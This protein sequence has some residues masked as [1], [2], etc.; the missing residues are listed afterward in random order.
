MSEPATQN[1]TLYQGTDFEAVFQF[2][3]ADGETPVSCLG[4]SLEAAITKGTTK[5]AT[6]TA[7]FTDA[8]QGLGRVS[9]SRTNVDA[10]PEG[11]HQWALAY[12][13]SFGKRHAVMAGTAVKKPFKTQ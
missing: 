13:D 12:I 1:L 6:L 3:Q 10:L 9:L 7:T 8:T 2:M 4:G 5:L 11:T